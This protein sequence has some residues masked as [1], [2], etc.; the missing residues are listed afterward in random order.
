MAI[1]ASPEELLRGL[2][3]NDGQRLAIARWT[4]ENL[5]GIHLGMD[6][7]LHLSEKYY[8]TLFQAMRIVKICLEFDKPP[9]LDDILWSPPYPLCPPITHEDDVAA[10][11]KLQSESFTPASTHYIDSEHGRLVSIKVYSPL[12]FCAGITG[13]GFVYDTGFESLWGASDNAASLVFFLN[14]AEHLVGITICKIE[15]KVCHLQVGCHSTVFLSFN[16]KSL[17]H[18]RLP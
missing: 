4:L 14:E 3:S 10:I 13:I 5:E 11:L 7:S 6:V 9:S 1:D 16:L 2:S 17:V 15:S 18:H 12:G 8:L